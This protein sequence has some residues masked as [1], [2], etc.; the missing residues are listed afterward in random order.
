MI[1]MYDEILSHLASDVAEDR[2]GSSWKIEASL[3]IGILS[4][5]S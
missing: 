1:I 5:C 4:C 2:H 3:E